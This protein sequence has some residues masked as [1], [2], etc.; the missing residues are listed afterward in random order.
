MRRTI[1][2]KKLMEV[3]SQLLILFRQ[4]KE[5]IKKQKRYPQRNFPH[6]LYVH[7]I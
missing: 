3:K 4:K 1:K 5:F 2:L 6:L 7:E